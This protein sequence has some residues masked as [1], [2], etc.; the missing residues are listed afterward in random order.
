MARCKASNALKFVLER[1]SEH[2]N[3]Y[4]LICPP[5]NCFI[6]IKLNINFLPCSHLDSP[7]PRDLLIHRWGSDKVKIYSQLKLQFRGVLL[8]VRS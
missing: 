5:V 1:N 3:I 4:T 6:S 7:T 2:S 8:G